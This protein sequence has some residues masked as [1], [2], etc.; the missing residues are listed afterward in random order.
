MDRIYLASPYSHPDRAV[1]ETRY[2]EAVK[3]AGRLMKDRLGC[4]VFSPIAHS[5]M[6]AELT[7]LPGDFDFWQGQDMGFIDFWA[8][9][10]AVLKLDGWRESMGVRAEIARA[11]SLGLPIE[12]LEP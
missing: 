12:Y 9:R 8:T 11:E 2:L 3:A 4:A 6:I 5:H 10:I 7:R 1:R